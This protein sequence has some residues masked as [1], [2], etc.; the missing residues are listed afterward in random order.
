[1]CRA[2][3]PAPGTFQDDGP[4]RPPGVPPSWSSLQ[5][6]A[7]ELIGPQTFGAGVVYGMGESA[8]GSLADLGQLAKTFILADLHDHARGSG[9]VLTLDPLAPVKGVLARAVALGFAD[10]LEE[11]YKEREA[12]IAE[13]RY[14]I[15]H[16]RDVFD[17]VRDDYAAQWTRFEELV[18]QRSLGSQFEA[19]RILG[20]LLLDLLSLI[21]AGAMAIKA[22]GKIPRLAKLAGKLRTAGSSAAASTGRAATPL[23]PSTRTA[24]RAA[25]ERV[26]P[27]AEPK[28]LRPPKALSKDELADWYRKQGDYFDD[29]KNLENHLE[30]TEFSKPV[31][32]RELPEGLEV[33]QYVRADGKPGMYFAKPGT[34]MELLGIQE[35]PPRVVQR[36]VVTKRL[37]VVESTAASLSREL[38]PG[39]GGSGGGQQLIFPKGWEESVTRI[40]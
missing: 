34:P 3:S 31:V 21:G 4:A 27:R 26:P 24:P 30:G 1:M 23:T 6:I 25:P 32:L 40:R 28:P 12:L 19:G 22:A 7:F 16:P 13:L 38:A 17:S 8:I 36:F 20:A 33:T 9:M 29:R 35:P 39:V 37:E 2:A 15:T 14:A 10:Q 5:Q 18:P 11:A